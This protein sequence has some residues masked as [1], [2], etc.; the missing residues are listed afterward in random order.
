[1]SVIHNMKT[2]NLLNKTQN[3]DQIMKVQLKSDNYALE[4]GERTTMSAQI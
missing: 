2:H 3:K 4:K 1:M